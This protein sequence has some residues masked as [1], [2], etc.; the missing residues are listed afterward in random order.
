MAIT[1][2]TSFVAA[3][4]ALSVNGVTTKLGYISGQVETAS[5]PV[6]FVR[7]PEN[8]E[9]PLTAD[10]EGGWPRLTAEVVIAV[11]PYAQNRHQQNY[12]ATV[13]LIDAL[14][15]ALRAVTPGAV[16]K[17]KLSWQIRA[18]QDYIGETLYWL[19]VARVTGN[20]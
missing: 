14:T 20:G 9:T 1:T 10:G 7:L 12:A 15:T 3:L 17:S 19:I 2:Y 18:A 11:E 6:L 4:G 8:A 5:L 16:A 13:T